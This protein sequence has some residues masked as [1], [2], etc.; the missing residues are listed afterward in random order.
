MKWDRLIEE[1]WLLR[2]V[3]AQ[4]AVAQ[5][6]VAKLTPLTKEATGL[7]QREVEACRD[8]VDA[9]KAF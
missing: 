1:A 9:K 4:L 3:S 5:Q 7:R 8:T 6:R 2:D